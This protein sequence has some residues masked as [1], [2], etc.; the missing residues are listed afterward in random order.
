MRD[1]QQEMPNNRALRFRA[2][3]APSPSV[4]ESGPY[5]EIVEPSPQTD[6]ETTSDNDDY[7]TPYE[8]LDARS[9]IQRTVPPPPSVYEDLTH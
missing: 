3:D 5:Q 7:D 1:D 4:M 9:V 8:G 6:Q 2:S